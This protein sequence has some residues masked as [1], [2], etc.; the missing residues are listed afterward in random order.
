MTYLTFL[1][2]ADA[3]EFSIPGGGN[4]RNVYGNLTTSS[5]SIVCEVTAKPVVDNY[6]FYDNSGQLLQV[7]KNDTYIITATRGYGRYYCRA[8]NA[9]GLSLDQFFFV[10]PSVCKYFSYVTNFDEVEGAYCF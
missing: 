10:Q 4:T 5:I 8:E 3:P 9:I 7:S 2:S 6:Y 1:L